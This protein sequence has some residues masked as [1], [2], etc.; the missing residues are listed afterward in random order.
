[1]DF[2]KDDLI[3]MGDEVEP[4]QKRQDRDDD[5]AQLVVPFGALWDLDKR[6]RGG[7]TRGLVVFG[8]R[9][10][11]AIGLRL[12]LLGQTSSLAEGV[13]RRRRHD[14]EWNGESRLRSEDQGLKR[15]LE[16]HENERGRGEKASPPRRT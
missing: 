4:G 9:G 3:G 12:L 10:R 16:T 11:R 13:R 15:R 14:C 6:V 1:M 8:R 7:L 2:V 5:Q